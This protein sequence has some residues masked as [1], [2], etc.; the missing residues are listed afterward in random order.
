MSNKAY[1]NGIIVVTIIMVGIAIFGVT[2]HFSGYYDPKGEIAKKKENNNN[3]KPKPTPNPDPKPEPTDKEIQGYK[4]KNN[5][6]LIL[7]G[8]SIINN[9]YVFISDGEENIVLFDITKKEVLNTFKSVKVASNNNYV[10]KNSDGKYAVITVFDDINELFKYEYTMIEYV[11]NKD[12]YI[13]TKQNS[14]FVA[15]KDGKTIT[16][17]YNAQIMDYN[18]LYIVTRTNN[19]EYHVFNFNNSTELTEYVS[20]KRI[21]IELVKNYVGVVT[22]DYMYRLFDF[23]NETN[24]VAEFQ[25]KNTVKKVHGVINSSYE[26]EIYEDDN[27]VKTIALK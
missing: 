4:C 6:C 10:V 20:A 3:N 5:D 26:L 12:N 16:L 18:D 24:L 1:L 14:S 21:Y 27:L 13:L 9:K 19:G 23:K 22:D 25:L 15:D 11:K 17:T 7:S 2:N 8:T